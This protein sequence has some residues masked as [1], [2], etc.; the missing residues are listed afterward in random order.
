MTQPPLLVL[1]R[2]D[3]VRCD[4][5]DAGWVHGQAA[6]LACRRVPRPGWSVDRRLRL[7]PQS[8]QHLS[9]FF[10]RA[11]RARHRG[12]RVLSA[13]R[14]PPAPRLWLRPDES[15]TCSSRLPARA[16]PSSPA[17]PPLRKGE[18]TFLTRPRRSKLVEPLPG[19]QRASAPA[20]PTPTGLDTPRRRRR[21]EFVAP[22]ASPTCWSWRCPSTSRISRA[23]RPTASAMSPSPAPT[24][25]SGPAEPGGAGGHR[26]SA[27]LASPGVEVVEP[28]RAPRRVDRAARHL[29]R[30][31]TVL[32][33]RGRA[34]PKHGPAR[35]RPRPF[36]PHTTASG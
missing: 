17:A 34:L 30:A 36:P 7:R 14:F 33:D 25:I 29:R 4:A 16:A 8:P 10:A 1:A 28:G 5:A 6:P 15:F 2:T 32:A 23:T 11:G 12:P 9:G 18:V 20:L 22:T 35:T 31:S 3:P 24:G 13:T 27:C 21:Q 19:Q 26:I